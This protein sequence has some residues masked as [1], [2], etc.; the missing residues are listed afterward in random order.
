MTDI[1]D[2]HDGKTKSFKHWQVI[3]ELPPGWVIDKTAGSPLHGYEFCHNGKSV[4][5]GQKRALVRVN[6][7]QPRAQ[8]ETPKAVAC[9]KPD[10]SGKPQQVIDAAYVRTVNELARQKFKQRLL[11]D[12]LCDLM[13]CE[14]EMWCKKEY[15]EELKKLIN[16]INTKGCI[17]VCVSKPESKHSNQLS[18]F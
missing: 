10:D 3:N 2:T 14:I 12:I 13:I 15:I 5:N 18:L 4:L 6:P 16:G 1:Q 8:E 17:E 11:N 7:P 9:E